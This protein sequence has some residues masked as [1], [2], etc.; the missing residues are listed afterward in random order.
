MISS[1]TS[2]TLKELSRLSGFSVST[3]SKAL[4]N[5]LDISLKTKEAIKDI[6]NKHNYIPNNY[7]VALRKKRT[8]F[9]SVIVPQVNTPF[10][11]C[12]LYNIQKAAHFL[13]YRIVLFQSFGKISKEKEFIKNSNDGSVDGIIILSEN[14][15]QNEHYKEENNL[16]IE[17]IQID[18]NLSNDLLKKECIDSFS[19]LIKSIN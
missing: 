15:F 5:K 19:K 3:V 12:F 2:V 1:E 10:F 4:N 13:G 7:A 6:A 8:K 14:A 16:P 17:Y 11:S 9:I 18:T